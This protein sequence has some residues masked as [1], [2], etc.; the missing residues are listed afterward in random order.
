VSDI[1]EVVCICLPN[2]T[3]LWCEAERG[4]EY[5]GKVM[6]KWKSEHPEYVGTGCDC[7]FVI[8]HMPRKD[9]RAIEVNNSFDWP[10]V[11]P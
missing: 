3:N 5:I 1:V 10:T 6:D 7:G 11:K 4:N 8:V 9:Y 2:G